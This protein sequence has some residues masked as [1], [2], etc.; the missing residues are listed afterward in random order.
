MTQ[1]PEPLDLDAVQQRYEAADWLIDDG[2]YTADCIRDVPLLVAEIQRLRATE[3][4]H[5]T[6]LLAAIDDW[7]VGAPPQPLW[8][9]TERLAQAYHEFQAETKAPGVKLALGEGGQS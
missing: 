8:W 5:L 3:Q 2:H 9:Y 7:W 6:K 1:T 4:P